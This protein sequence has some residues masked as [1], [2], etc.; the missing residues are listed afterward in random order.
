MA[1]PIVLCEC[2]EAL[3]VKPDWKEARCPHCSRLLCRKDYSE[4]AVDA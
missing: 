1:D 4:D 2:E 3:S